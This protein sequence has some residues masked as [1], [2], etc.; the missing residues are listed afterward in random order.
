[1]SKIKFHQKSNDELVVEI[2]SDTPLYV[3]DELNKSLQSKGLVEDLNKSTLSVRYFYIGEVRSVA[4]D[5]I[6][7]LQSMVKE[8]SP[9]DKRRREMAESVGVTYEPN[10]LVPKITQSSTGYKKIS[11]EPSTLKIPKMNKLIKDDVE[12]SNYGPKGGNQ[13]TD[14]D[15]ARRKTNNIGDS[16]GFGPN[17]NIKSYSSKPGQLS[18]KSQAAHLTAEQNKK[19]QKQPVKV[20]SEEEKTALATKMGL[21]KNW[22]N[23][24]SIPSAEDEILRFAQQNVIKSGEDIAAN[25]LAAIMHNKSMLNDFR[26]PTDHDMISHGEAI[27]LGVS[28]KNLVKQDMR[29]DSTITNWLSEASKPISNRFN[30]E[31]EEAEYWANIKISDSQDDATGY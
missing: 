9:G 15:N 23:H 19:N 2:T 12:K 18:A 21:K 7:T 1:M 11:D 5:L 22:I 29:W 8:E 10:K 25:Q 14:S 31:E 13:Y 4:D 16:I 17:T 27:G 6:K 3:V 24:N 28:Q 26:Q 20:Y 30:S